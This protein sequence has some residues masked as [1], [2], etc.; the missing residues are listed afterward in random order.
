MFSHAPLFKYF[1]SK[2]DANAHFNSVFSIIGRFKRKTKN[3]VR[4]PF[5]KIRISIT[6]MHLRLKQTSEICKRIGGKDERKNVSKCPLCQF[7]LN[8]LFIGKRKT[9]IDFLL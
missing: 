3:E 1:Y 9:L 6:F 2:V 8:P 5:I 4:F 7:F